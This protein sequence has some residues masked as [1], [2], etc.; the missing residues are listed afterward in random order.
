MTASMTSD[1]TTPAAP[2]QLL[3]ARLPRWLL[4]ADWPGDAL[5][6]AYAE[7]ADL[8]TSRRDGVIVDSA[9]RS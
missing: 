9:C 8:L 3:N 5:R 4:P 1:R 2:G 7:F 6:A